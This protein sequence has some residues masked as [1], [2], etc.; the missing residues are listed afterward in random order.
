MTVL[1]KTT[2][3]L[4]EAVV[5]LQYE[6]QA[7]IWEEYKTPGYEK[8]LRDARYHF[9]Y[10]AEALEADAPELFISY[11]GWV[12]TLFAGLKFSD[13]VLPVTLECMRQVLKE[14]LPEEERAPALK[15]IEAALANLKDM[16]ATPPS[17][18]VGD[19]PLDLLAR[20][21][22]AALLDGNRASASRMI[23]GAVDE[24]VPIKEIYLQVFQRVQHEIGRLWQ[25]NRISVA[26]E[27]YCTAATQVIM[28]QLYPRI[29]SGDKNGYALVATCVGNELHE[30]G[31]RMV[32]DFF[33]M[34]GWDTYFLGANTP[35]A[36]VLKMLKERNAALLAISATMTYHLDEAR[37]LIAETRRSGLDTRIL[38]GGYPFNRAP[39]LWKQIGADGYAP[40]AQQAV[41]VA[42]RLLA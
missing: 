4:A 3:T 14:R 29:F 32:A 17:L 24:G 1:R 20:R 26:Q 8:S 12:K 2:D 30:I 9:D 7:K 6:R 15:L 34:S 38:V 19:S 10:L 25:S 18:L 33:E 22:L 40:D 36:E 28:S 42:E 16:P 5:K 31:A 11:V 41:I 13:T 39:N 27:H 23:L 37:E 35:A 21:Y